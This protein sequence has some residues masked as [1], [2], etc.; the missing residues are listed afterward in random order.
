[1][2]RIITLFFGVALLVTACGSRSQFDRQLVEGCRAG[3]EHVLQKR[4]PAYV[5]K[6][7][8]ETAFGDSDIAKSGRR[9][10]MRADIQAESGAGFPEEREIICHFEESISLAGLVYSPAFY[11]IKLGNERFG[12]DAEGNL[13]NDITSFS[14]LSDTVAQALNNA[15]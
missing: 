5:L 2:I 14:N 11:Q 7:L 10:T 3:A 1:M 4:D 6:N 8:N 13:I 9:V 12:R 15:G